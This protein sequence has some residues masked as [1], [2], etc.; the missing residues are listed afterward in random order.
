MR[1]KRIR[2]SRRFR[3]SFSHKARRLNKRNRGFHRG[4]IRF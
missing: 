4:G 2:N 3:R 1:R